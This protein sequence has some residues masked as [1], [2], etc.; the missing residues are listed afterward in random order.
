MPS[1]HLNRRSFVAT[2]LAGALMTALPAF[3]QTEASAKA[4]VVSVVDEINRVI[5]DTGALQYTIDQAH[6]E[7]AL[8]KQSIAELSDGDHKQALLFLA[9][10][11]VE[12][13]H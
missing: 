10:Y 5:V 2:G 4:L 6:R 13:N 3:A 8:A 9:E 7:A 1:N 12:R 11:A